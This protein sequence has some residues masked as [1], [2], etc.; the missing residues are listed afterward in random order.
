MTQNQIL[1]LARKIIDYIKKDF[2]EVHLS[3]NL[4]DNIVYSFTERG[5]DIEIP[6]EIYDIDLYVEK[7]VIVYTGEGSYAQ[8]V[9]ITGGFSKEHKSYVEISIRNAINDWLKENNFKVKE[10]TEL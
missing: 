1:D 7:G 6:A 3:G 2:E 4:M 8:D 10:Y 9:N 5:I